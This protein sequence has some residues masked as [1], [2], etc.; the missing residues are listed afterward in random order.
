MFVLCAFC[1]RFVCVDYR[2]VQLS[3]FVIEYSYIVFVTLYP[4]QHLWCSGNISAFQALA[5]DSISGRCNFCRLSV[6]VMHFFAFCV[7]ATQLHFDCR[8]Y[9]IILKEHTDCNIIT[10]K[11]LDEFWTLLVFV[12]FTM[13][14]K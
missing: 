1:V 7:V 10:K 5:L 6:T 4:Q 11:Q 8:F 14:N 9:A 12:S 13:R 3:V 2:S